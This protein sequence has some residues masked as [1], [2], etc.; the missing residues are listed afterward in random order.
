MVGTDAKSHDLVLELIVQLAVESN[1]V[2]CVIRQ[3]HNETTRLVAQWMGHNTMVE[4][5]WGQAA[6]GN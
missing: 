1:I 6:K 5:D 4:L 3:R 2:N